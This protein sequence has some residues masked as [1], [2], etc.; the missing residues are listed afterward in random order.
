[1]LNFNSIKMKNFITLLLSLTLTAVMAQN[2]DTQKADELFERMA[3]SDAAD[4]Y[5]KLLK[6]GKG[7]RYVFAQLGNCYYQIND[8]KKRGNLF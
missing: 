5:K 7:G 1:M 2:K 6:R 4:A 3:Y 8:L